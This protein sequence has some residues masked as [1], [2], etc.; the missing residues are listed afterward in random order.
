MRADLRQRSKRHGEQ[1]A[2]TSSV[3]FADTFPSRGRQDRAQRGDVPKQCSPLRTILSGAEG[4]P[5]SKGK[6]SSDS[7][8]DEVMNVPIRSNARCRPRVDVGIDP[9]G[10]LS[11]RGIRNTPHP[12]TSWTPSPEGEGFLSLQILLIRGIDGFAMIFRQRRPASRLS[13]RFAPILSEKYKLYPFIPLR[14]QGAQPGKC[15][16]NPP[17]K[18]ANTQSRPA[19]IIPTYPHLMLTH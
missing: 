6:L 17:E 3:S 4:F 8:T 1:V 12:P 5:L 9:Y 2:Y 13:S 15:G 7:E 11:A 14:K 18:G 19:L 16:F 10:I